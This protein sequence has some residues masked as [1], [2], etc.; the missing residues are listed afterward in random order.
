MWLGAMLEYAPESSILGHIPML[1]VIIPTLNEARTLPVTLAA[2]RG[3]A[4][5]EILVVDAGSQDRTAQIARNAGA[6]VLQ[7]PQRQRSAQLNLGAQHGCGDILLFV[8]A[9]TILPPE[10]VRMVEQALANNEVVGGG[11]ARRFRSSSPFL[12]LT[13]AAAEIRNRTIGWHLGDQAMFAR[14]DIFRAL[15]GFR[16]W[17]RF[18]DLDLSRRLGLQGRLVTLRPPVVTSA[19]RFDK[20]G[21]LR[22]TL[23]DFWWT[24]QY[25]SDSSRSPRMVDRPENRPVS[26]PTQ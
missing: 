23:R 2:L 25:W 10:G 24:L 21:P 14:A 13:C 6:R 11:F 12:K 5:H 1:S 19:R 26:V 18:E 8:H 22:Q 15:G 7:S 17:D 16:C 3:Q 4:S 20:E 9:D